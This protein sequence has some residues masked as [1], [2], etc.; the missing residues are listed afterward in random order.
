[1]STIVCD[2]EAAIAF[3]RAIYAP[4][5]AFR[6][7][8]SPFRMRLESDGAF[9]H[10]LPMSVHHIF[11]PRQ[12][13][14]ASPV[15]P[16][17]GLASVAHRLHGLHGHRLPCKSCASSER[18]RKGHYVKNVAGKRDCEDRYYRRWSCVT[19]GK[20]SCPSLSNATY[21]E[22]AKSQLDRASF[23]SAV[24]AVRGDFPVES[25]EHHRVGLL[26]QD[27]ASPP[28]CPSWSPSLKRKAALQATPPSTKRQLRFFEAGDER[29]PRD[30]QPGGLLTPIQFSEPPSASSAVTARSA[31]TPVTAVADSR[32]RSVSSPPPDPIELLVDIRA[33][34]D[35]FFDAL[36]R[37]EAD[38]DRTR[39]NSL[40]PQEYIGIHEAKGLSLRAIVETPTLPDRSSQPAA[41]PPRQEASVEVCPPGADT[42]FSADKRDVPSP[43]LASTLAAD[44]HSADGPGKKA[45]RK[46]A[47]QENITAAF[48]QEV[49]RLGAL[50]KAR[51]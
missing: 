12:T 34:L 46:R 33:G 26:L 40:S 35:R 25:L 8:I 36:R 5:P 1:M 13:K 10:F 19:S 42:S 28:S 45:A 14:K 3:A 29:S 43:S 38:A 48:E 15:S 23:S 4:A 16:E 37:R 18:E 9:R 47:R 51:A 31:C 21:I 6:L 2:C 30:R 44:F 24:E 27:G 39:E 20:F 49:C 17:N 11:A 41:L 22:W 50:S 32:S 7:A